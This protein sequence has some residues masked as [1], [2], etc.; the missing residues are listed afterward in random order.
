MASVK[1]IVRGEAQRESDFADFQ[2]RA[3]EACQLY[4][5]RVPRIGP[6]EDLNTY[7]R[8]VLTVLQPHSKDWKNANLMQ[9]YS[10]ANSVL[11][12]AEKNIIDDAVTEFKKPVGPLRSVMVTDPESG[13][14]QRRWYGDPANC[15]DRFK[16]PLQ[17]V[18]AWDLSLAKGRNAPGAIVPTSVMM[19]DGTIRP[20]R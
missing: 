6:G 17:R 4:G 16:G 12:I 5:V 18:T 9:P 19:S 2:A 7:R 14:R 10:I 11:P 20:A 15:W 8:R 3:D 1:D 13:Q